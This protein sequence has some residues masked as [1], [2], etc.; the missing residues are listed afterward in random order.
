M[1]FAPIKK[2]LAFFCCILVAIIIADQLSNI[3]VA[4]SGVSGWSR[5]PVSFILYAVLFL[6]VLYAIGGIFGISFFDMNRYDR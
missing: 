4:A 2:W 5:I 3:I 1:D 6:A